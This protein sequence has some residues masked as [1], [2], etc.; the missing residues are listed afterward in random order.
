[1]HTR[2]PGGHRQLPDWQVLS[3]MHSALVQ[4]LVEGMHVAPHARVPAPQTQVE[5]EQVPPEVQSTLL[6]QPASKM[7]LAP[8]VLLPGGQSQPFA[9]HTCAPLQAR[10]P[11]QAQ[12]TPRQR[13]LVPV[14]S[15]SM[16]QAEA[17]MQRPSHPRMPASQPHE[18]QS[19]VWPQPSGVMPHVP[20]MSG[21]VRGT[22]A[23]AGHPPSAQSS[24]GSCAHWQPAAKMIR[25][26]ERR[27]PER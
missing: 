27:T 20:S 26:S 14:Q 3:C 17:R 1:M 13:L 21:Q 4:Q 24:A 18:P 5:L 9:P 15:E 16:Q 2:C 22:H 25:A 6:Q 12:V 19:S 10:L 11:L 23:S 8:Q 7:Q